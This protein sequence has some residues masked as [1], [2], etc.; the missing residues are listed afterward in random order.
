[1]EVGAMHALHSLNVIALC[2]MDHMKAASLPDQ[3]GSQ[4]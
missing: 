1:M 4:T 2:Q 3:S